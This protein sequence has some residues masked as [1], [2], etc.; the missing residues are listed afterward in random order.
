MEAFTGAETLVGSTESFEA[1]VSLVE[2]TLAPVGKVDASTVELEVAPEASTRGEV[3]ASESILLFTKVSKSLSRTS[4]DALAYAVPQASLT[5]GDELTLAFAN[6]ALDRVRAADALVADTREFGTLRE[7]RV[8]IS[9]GRDNFEFLE[10]L[11]AANFNQG[12]V[13]LVAMV[14][15][16]SENTF[17]EN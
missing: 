2:G 16:R 12:W 14:A 3:C 9:W 6:R 11:V 10:R 7:G 17:P 5:L 13:F 1:K 4:S 15:C 8:G